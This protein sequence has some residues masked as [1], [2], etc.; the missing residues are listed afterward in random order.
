[1]HS[2]LLVL[3]VFRVGSMK[4]KPSLPYIRGR[5][6]CPADTFNAH[7]ANLPTQL[8]KLCQLRK[9]I[10]TTV[11]LLVSRHRC[12]TM[13]IAVS[14][15]DTRAKHK[16]FLALHMYTVDTIDACPLLTYVQAHLTYPTCTRA[17]HVVSLGTQNSAAGTYYGGSTLLL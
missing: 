14:R 11:A 5:P 12:T 7:V 16:D 13:G 17:T 3:H 8:A 1:M 9:T 6:I 15:T 10:V 4:D 2:C